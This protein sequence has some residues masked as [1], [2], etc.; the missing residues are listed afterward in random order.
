MSAGP[1]PIEAG[2][3]RLKHEQDKGISEW[4]RDE[5]DRRAFA[6][7]DVIADA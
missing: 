7:D 3:Q 5:L 4:I 6:I 2:L 1:L